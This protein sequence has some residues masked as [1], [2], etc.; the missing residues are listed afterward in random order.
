[1]SEVQA[2]DANSGQVQLKNLIFTM[3]WEDPESDVKALGI[4]PADRLLTI[5]SGGCNTLHFLLHDPQVVYAVDINEAQS[6]LLDLKIAAMRMLDHNHFLVL[7]GIRDPEP[8]T[9]P[10]SELLQSVAESLPDDCRRYWESRA[11]QSNDGILGQGRYE[12]FIR[13]FRRLLGALQGRRRILGLFEAETLEEQETYFTNV[14]ETSRWR[15]LFSAFFNKWVLARRGL[16][17]DYFQFD[18]G[19]A[20]YA[21]SFYRRS[22]RVMTE[23]PIRGNYFL[24]QY[25]LG[26]YRSEQEV[27]AYLDPR[28]YEVI[29]S[30]LDRIQIITAD[31]KEW[32]EK[33]KPGSIDKFGL[34]NICEVM[35]LRETTRTFEAILHA[36]TPGARICFRNLMVPR[37]VPEELD[38]QFQR[39]REECRKLRLEDRSFVYG[40]VDALRIV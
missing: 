25:L 24:A 10:R 14:W 39:D 19:S 30:R 20:S 32:L 37:D 38:K 12:R 4:G 6:W 31:V 26:R 3:S 5:T 22:S 1:M 17:A 13:Q 33:Q 15:L 9:P 29:R 8:G 40:R 23:M 18:D 2:K 34:S 16:S 21:E 28:H 11:G 7:M 36:G 35:D 27:P